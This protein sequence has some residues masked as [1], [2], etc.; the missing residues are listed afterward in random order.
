MTGMDR[1]DQ[2][3]LQALAEKLRESPVETPR[4]R[5][6]PFREEDFPAYFA[7]VTQPELYRLAGSPRV[8][9][10]TQAREL[11]AWCLDE[12]QPNRPF[13]IAL[14]AGDEAAGLLTFTLH[15]HLRHHPR[16]QGLRGV[17]LSFGLRGEY[18]RQGLMTELLPAFFAWA[19]TVGGLDYVNAGSFLGNTASRRLQEKVGMVLFSSGTYALGAETL[20]TEERIVFKPDL[21]R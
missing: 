8:S 7:Y 1:E 15:P 11:F 19:F 13:A 16:L 4:L 5:L 20:T 18:R 9:S 6:R 2:A 21:T 10:I 3:F 17:C 14:R 12:G